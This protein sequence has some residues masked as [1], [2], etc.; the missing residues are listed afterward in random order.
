MLAPHV[1]HEPA[2]VG[3]ND[4]FGDVVLPTIRTLGFRPTPESKFVPWLHAKLALLGELWW[5]DEDALG[6]V[7]DVIGFTPHRLWLSSANFTTSR[8]S[9]DFGLWTDDAAHLDH[10]E[11]FLVRLIAKSEDLVDA[12][13]TVKPQFLPVEFDDEPFADYVAEFGW[14]D[15]DESDDQDD[16]RQ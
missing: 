14:G 7:T 6:H 9:L 3:P 16:D 15:E 2:L 4:R 13:D 1:N 5:H 11:Q 8:S 12:E 10:A